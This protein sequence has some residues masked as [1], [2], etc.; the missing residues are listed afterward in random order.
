MKPGKVSNAILKR[1]VLKQIKKREEYAD[2]P[3]IGIDTGYLRTE[4]NNLP[5]VYSSVSVGSPWN[6]YKAANN[7]YAAGARPVA[8][9][10]GIV[11]PIHAEE[12][13]LRLL[14][15]ELEHE[16]GMHGMQISGGHTTVSSIVEQPVISVTA[17]G[18]A[19][20]DR[21]LSPRQIMP[22]Q[23]IVMTKWIGIG[24]IRQIIAKN[25]TEILKFYREAVLDKAYGEEE[26]LSVEREAGLAYEQ[27]SYMHDVSEGGIFAALWDLAE[28]AKVGLQVDFKKIPVKQEIIEICEI[29][30]MNPYEL[31]STGALLCVTGNGNELVKKLT[32]NGVRAAVIGTVTQG[33]DK[34]IVNVDETRYL[35]A[36]KVDELYRFI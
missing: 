9:E 13:A 11:L 30:D 31:E 8:A 4:K 22:G 24:G 33:H 34:I 21:L 20:G 35:D 2:K 36:P 18:I 12:A 7:I 23:D 1:S 3:G 26:D 27:V 14:M 15:E 29:F 10:L 28:A 5:A 32:D 25:R 17:L 19:A 6:V 16:C